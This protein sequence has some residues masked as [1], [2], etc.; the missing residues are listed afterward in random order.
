M[1]CLSKSDL[2][3]KISL[4]REQLI[5]YNLKINKKELL[6]L[7]KQLDELILEYTKRYLIN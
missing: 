4:L 3:K 6:E 1:E 7:S 5:D 2:H